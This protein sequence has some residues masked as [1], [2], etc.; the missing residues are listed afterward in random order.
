MLNGMILKIIEIYIIILK[1]KYNGTRL[2]LLL[3][4]VQNIEEW[5]KA[6]NSFLVDINAQ[7]L[8]Y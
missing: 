6:V 4:E 2:Y 1:V 7:M 8:T 5:E 3:D